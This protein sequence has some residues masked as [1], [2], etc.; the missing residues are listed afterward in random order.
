MAAPPYAVALCVWGGRISAV[1][2]EQEVFSSSCAVAAGKERTV[3][4]H[5]ATVVPGLTD[6][7]P[8]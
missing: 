1:G 8:T 4:L 3:D 2:S 5:G 7:M 6:S